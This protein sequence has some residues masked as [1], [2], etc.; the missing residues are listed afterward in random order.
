M[1]TQRRETARRH[2]RASTDSSI[3]SATLRRT[4]RAQNNQ[5]SSRHSGRQSHASST[6]SRGV[7]KRDLDCTRLSLTHDL[8]GVRENER[9]VR[10]EDGKDVTPKSLLEYFEK[11]NESVLGAECGYGDDDEEE[12]EE[13]ERDLLSSEDD[14]DAI[15]NIDFTKLWERWEMRDETRRIEVEL[16]PLDTIDREEENERRKRTTKKKKKRRCVFD[17][18]IHIHRATQTRTHPSKTIG[19]STVTPE[20]KEIGTCAFVAKQNRRKKKDSSGPSSSKSTTTTLNNIDALFLKRAEIIID[21][22]IKARIN[23]NKSL[24]YRGA[25]KTAAGEDE[26]CGTGNSDYVEKKLTYLWEYKYPINLTEFKNKKGERRVNAIKFHPQF[27]GIVAIC[28]GSIDAKEFIPRDEFDD[29]EVKSVDFESRRDGCVNIWSLRDDQKPEISLTLDSAVTSISFQKRRYEDLRFDAG[30]KS[31]LLLCG[32]LDGSVNCFDLAA[33]ARGGEKLVEE[34]AGLFSVAVPK[35]IYESKPEASHREPTW[36]IAFV[37]DDETNH[38]RNLFRFSALSCSTDGT[39]FEWN[40]KRA[41]TPSESK[42]N[43]IMHL[44]MNKNGNEKQHFIS[45]GKTVLE[46]GPVCEDVSSEVQATCFDIIDN[47]HI[48][49]GSVRGDVFVCKR[50]K[51]VSDDIAANPP[52]LAYEVIKKIKAHSRGAS[53]LTPIYAIE[54]H[55]MIKGV[56][57]TASADGTV[58]V[59]RVDLAPEGEQE[60]DIELDKKKTNNITSEIVLDSTTLS[61]ESKSIFQEYDPAQI[62]SFPVSRAS[63]FAPVNDI[64]WA[65][66][67]RKI[68]AVY[69]DGTLR[70]FDCANTTDCCKPW[71]EQTFLDDDDNDDEEEEENND[72][73][74]R[75]TKTKCVQLTAVSYANAKNGSPVLAIGDYKGTVRL[76]STATNQCLNE[77]LDIEELNNVFNINK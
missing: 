64:S 54:K 32:C 30:E 71:Y 47:E 58:R 34:T 11:M 21:R 26:E 7:N 59:F 40:A 39:L 12:E 22:Q 55:P 18:E 57:A 10:D 36:D 66:D 29:D 8:K 75:A 9:V 61:L 48:L 72:K 73:T 41:K 63:I 60:E 67:G 15:L 16:L 35:L 23:I 74:Q 38:D 25:M 70:V 1:P 44:K 19:T 20:M 42:Q 33:F 53:L 77:S 31:K 52:P 43:T 17:S 2:S 24:R 4:A 69:D 37:D 51:Q 65:N 50:L 62:V 14:D 56:F 6:Y 3:A 5:S 49:V 46:N 76:F 45:T 13:E 68:A 28:H 27:D